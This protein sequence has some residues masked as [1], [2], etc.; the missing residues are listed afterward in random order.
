MAHLLRCLLASACGVCGIRL[1]GRFVGA[2]HLHH[3][4]RPSDTA[5]YAMMSA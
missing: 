4:R 3:S 2:S 5:R 1:G